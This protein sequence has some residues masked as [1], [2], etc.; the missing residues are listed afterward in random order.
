MDK[1]GLGASS[2]ALTG[3]SILLGGK[4]TFGYTGD[5]TKAPEFEFVT[6]DEDSTGIV[7]AVKMTVEVE[8]LGA[9]YITHMAKGEP[10]VLKGNVSDDGSNVPL[11][12]TIQGQLHKLSPEFKVGDKVKRQF[13]LRVD[14]YKELVD[15]VSTIEYTRHPYKYVLGG[16]DMTSNFSDNV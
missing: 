4:N 7:K 6:V 15:G 3:L 9:D 8:N 5:G 11:V 2:Q 16:V 13:E 1:H 12:A 14:L 10:F